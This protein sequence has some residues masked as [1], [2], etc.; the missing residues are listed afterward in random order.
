MQKPSCLTSTSTSRVQT[1]IVLELVLANPSRDT[2]V[3]VAAKELVNDKQFMLA[4]VRKKLAH[5][6]SSDRDFAAH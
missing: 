2:V 5:S 4:C 6:L 1:Y 3:E